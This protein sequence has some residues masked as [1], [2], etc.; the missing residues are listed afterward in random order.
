[1]KKQE[2]LEKKVYQPSEIKVHQLKQRQIITA[3]TMCPNP[4]YTTTS[5]NEG[6]WK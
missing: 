2:Q 3:S 6:P 5:T 1:M 4:N